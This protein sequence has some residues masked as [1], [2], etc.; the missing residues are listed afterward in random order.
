MAGGGLHEHTCARRGSFHAP[1]PI[2]PQQM[3]F[4]RFHDL[5]SP[6]TGPGPKG[7]GSARER[8]GPQSAPQMRRQ[9]ASQRPVPHHAGKD[10]PWKEGQANYKTSRI[11]RQL[12]P[13]RAGHYPSPARGQLRST[14]TA[15]GQPLMIWCSGSM[16]PLCSDKH[17]AAHPGRTALPS[18]HTPA[19]AATAVYVEQAAR[20]AWGVDNRQR[21]QHGDDWAAAWQHAL[22]ASKAPTGVVE[23]SGHPS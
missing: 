12:L 16:W 23:R 18:K 11:G 19:A 10:A 14:V 13:R 1:T 7:R 20:W 3:R 15:Y 9:T 8:D 21:T 17:A 5:P 4:A 22:R 6:S 2:S